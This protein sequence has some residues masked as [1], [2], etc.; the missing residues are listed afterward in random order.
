MT[1]NLKGNTVHSCN[2]SADTQGYPY[3]A[4]IE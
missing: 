4:F 2:D 3:A 1:S